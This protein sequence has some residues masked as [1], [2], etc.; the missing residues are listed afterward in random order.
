[1]SACQRHSMTFSLL[2]D[3]SR[4]DMLHI[5]VPFVDF[6]NFCFVLFCA[7]RHSLSKSLLNE[8]REIHFACCHDLKEQGKTILYNHMAEDT[9]TSLELHFTTW[10]ERINA[11]SREAFEVVSSIDCI[12]VRIRP[13]YKHDCHRNR[14]RPP[15]PSHNHQ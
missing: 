9:E 1:M 12:F 2:W 11:S 3:L 14:H 15:H 5:T 8:F 10:T 13:S 4:S 7:Q 6:L